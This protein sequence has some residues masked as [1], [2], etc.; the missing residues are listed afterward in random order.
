[1]FSFSLIISIFGQN[2]LLLFLRFLISSSCCRVSSTI[3][4]SF[5]FFILISLLSI[6]ISS[7]S[8]IEIIL[9]LFFFSSFISDNFSYFSSISDSPFI[10]IRSFSFLFLT[11]S[12][13]VFVN[14]CFDIIIPFDPGFFDNIPIICAIMS[15]PTFLLQSF[16][17]TKIIP[18]LSCIIASIPLSP[19]ICPL[20]VVSVVLIT[21]IPRSLILV[22]TSSSY[23]FP[24][25]FADICLIDFSIFPFLFS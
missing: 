11:S 9:F 21:S 24:F 13:A 20:F 19:I 15:V 1:M 12:I 4:I 18:F 17:C 2:L 6:I 10:N 25:S 22:I 7:A 5:G 14:P 23:F 3:S 8:S 16:I